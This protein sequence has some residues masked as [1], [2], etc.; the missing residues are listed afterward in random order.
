M[1]LYEQVLIILAATHNFV[2]EFIKDYK[3]DLEST[4][5]S[6]ETNLFEFANDNDRM[7][8]FAPFYNLLPLIDKSDFTFN[9]NPL[10]FILNSFEPV[11][12]QIQ[13][14]KKKQ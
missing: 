11:F 2:S 5:V 10:L 12:Y 8:L 3:K 4:C 9:D 14:E 13:L 6:Y 7:N 1:K